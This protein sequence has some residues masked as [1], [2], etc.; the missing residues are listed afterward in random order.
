M[1]PK[2]LRRHAAFAAL[3]LA[4]LAALVPSSLARAADLAV[5]IPDGQRGTVT[6][7]GGLISCPPRCTAV[8]LNPITPVVLTAEPG[9]GWSLLEW[10]GCRSNRFSRLTCTVVGGG[11]VRATFEELRTIS[12]TL[13]PGEGSVVSEPPGLTCTNPPG[14]T[15]TSCTATFPLRQ[16]VTFAANVPSGW[17]TTSPISPPLPGGGTSA[18]WGAGAG[19]ACLSSI[20]DPL[21]CTVSSDDLSRIV[22]VVIG[23]RPTPVVELAAIGAGTVKATRGMSTVSASDAAERCGGWSECRIAY[24]RGTDVVF[25]ALPEAGRRFVGWSDPAC[26][27]TPICRRRVDWEYISLAALFDPV[28]VNVIYAFASGLGDGL[29]TSDPP[30]IRCPPV[31]TAP[32]ALGTRLSLTARSGAGIP[33]ARFPF[34]CRDLP[35]G[36]LGQRCELVVAAE[37]TWVGVNV[38][39][40]EDPGQPSSFALQLGVAVQGQ[41]RVLGGKVDCG[42]R[43]KAQYV[44]GSEEVLSATPNPGW[45]F[46]SW[47]GPGEACGRANPCAISPGLVTALTAKFVPDPPPISSSTLRI[48]RAGDGDGRV[49]VG[50]AHCPPT[51]SF[52]AD[53]G[54]AITATAVPSTG[55]RFAGWIGGACQ[56]GSPCHVQLTGDTSLTAR[57]EKEEEPRRRVR[58]RVSGSG[59]GGVQFADGMC[60]PKCDFETTASS[61]VL[62]AKAKSTSRFVAWTGG[63]CG[64]VPRCEGRLLGF[65][66]VIRVRFDPHPPEIRLAGVGVTSFA[67]QRVVVARVTA[68]RGARISVSLLDG[69]RVVG[70]VERVANQPTTILRLPAPLRVGPYRARVVVQV[71]KRRPTAFVVTLRV[72]RGA[73]AR[74]PLERV[75]LFP[76]PIRWFG[77]S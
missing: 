2:S 7:S 30:G 18:Y 31:C 50:A 64:R 1:G 70:E 19:V 22:F 46:E 73:R 6:A 8:G 55:S 56:G 5:S 51:C 11:S 40:T 38:G 3:L 52:T 63:G 15:S 67:G 61:V 14:E 26:G 41:G 58:I 35:L 28:S 74:A 48:A 69:M 16:S 71:G 33:L 42:T 27:T 37:P 13:G 68:P 62:F 25:E 60:P 75:A 57:F 45:R 54:S 77:L 24:P 59:R 9:N 17:T 49:R 53:T 72:R 12:L 76:G 44:V 23:F 66:T 47:I 4:I 20:A 34:G 43:C 29:V 36:G 65:Q 10:S 39:G 32:F 21:R